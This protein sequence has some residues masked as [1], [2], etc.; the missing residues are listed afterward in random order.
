[1]QKTTPQMRTPNDDKFRE[2]VLFLAEKS[3]GDRPFGAIKLNK[4]L[5]YVDFIAYLTLGEAV[6]NH[7][8]QKLENGPAPR[9]F[10]PLTKKMEQKGEIAYRVE[11]YFGKEKRRMVALRDPDLSGFS[12]EE[13]ALIDNV[14]AEF[15]GKNATEMSEMS[16]EFIGWKL[17]EIGEDIPY[18]VALV[19]AVPANKKM[20]EYGVELR[21]LA[22]E[23]LEHQERPSAQNNKK[24][25]V[26]RRAR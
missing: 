7:K 17:A 11:N 9:A 22:K 24:Q 14:V 25:T 23:L 21:S 26:P 2:L 3:T 15:W 13:V 18:D 5:F 10:L 8:Y 1:M 12:G 16:H 6:T 19:R 4:L 20:E